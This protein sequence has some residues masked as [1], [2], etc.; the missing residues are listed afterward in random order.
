MIRTTPFHPRLAELN[1]TGLWTHWAGHL[2]APKYDMASKHEYFGVRQ[3][4]GFFDASPLY[5]YSITG[6]DA[7]N[8]LGGILARDVRTCRP[9]RAQYTVWCDDAGYV[10]EDGVVFR[11]SANDF[12]LTAAEPNLSFLESHIGS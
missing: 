2:A 9:G 1:A 10:L 11:H 6:R 8:F 4:V 12:L 7:E 5:K 3:A